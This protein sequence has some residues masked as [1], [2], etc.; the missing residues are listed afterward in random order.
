M[1]VNSN[2]T[3]ASVTASALAVLFGAETAVAVESEMAV[4]FVA[5]LVASALLTAADGSCITYHARVIFAR[6][7]PWFV[8]YW[9]AH[10]R[11]SLLPAYSCHKN[12]RST[13][14]TA[15]VLAAAIIGIPE[16]QVLQPQSGGS[17]LQCSHT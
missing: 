1:L 8:W 11:D 10:I 13:F 5:V 6:H 2:I 15:T 3:S 7:H 14:T 17:R 16:E 4:P 9:N 12:S